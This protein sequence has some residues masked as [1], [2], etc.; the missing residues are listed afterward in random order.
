[1]VLPPNTIIEVPQT[2]VVIGA[3]S[4]YTW[5]QIEPWVVSL[6][7][8]GYKGKKVIVA[9]DMDFETAQILIGKG[10]VVATF[11]SDEENKTFASPLRDVRSIVSFRFLHY[12]LFFRNQ[13]IE[14][15][16]QFRYIIATD[17]KDVIF[18]TNP[19]EW[20]ED[21]LYP[22]KINVGS[23]GLAYKNEPWGNQNLK[24][25]FG[26]IIHD[27]LKNDTIY[28]AGTFA[29]EAPYMRDLFLNIWMLCQTNPIVNPD[30]AALNV[31][32]S[33]KPWA[34]ITRF[35]TH[36]DGWAC[37]CGTV[38]DPRKMKD[39]RIH[40]QARNTE[41]VFRDGIVYVNNDST[42]KF[43]LV[44]QYDRNPEFFTV[45]DKKYREEKENGTQIVDSSSSTTQS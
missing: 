15:M 14:D 9:Y 27:Y 31:L 3:A 41:P 8:S 29:G 43:C 2:D 28:N 1:M 6:E 4:G 30:Q 11:K 25:S 10:F 17:V 37:Q 18:Q 20:L 38:A 21:N 44:H 24:D 39:F 34:D 36:N 33:T 26:E 7:R 16:A 23:E 35:N 42:N 32:L 5:P 22:F 40:L 12:W 13:N 19:S 45:L